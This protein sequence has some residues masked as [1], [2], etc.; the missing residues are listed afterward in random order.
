MRKW[1]RRIGAAVVVLTLLCGM[2]VSAEEKVYLV[3]V[4]RATNHVD[5]YAYDEQTGEYTIPIIEFTCSTGKDNGTP[6]AV[7][8]ISERDKFHPMNGGV[9]AQYAVR[10][11]RGCMFHAVPTTEQKKSTL[12]TSYYNKLGE[13]A[14]SGCVRL[15]AADSNWIYENC[16]DGTTVEVYEDENDLGPFGKPM[17]PKIPDGHPYADWDPTDPDPNNPWIEERPIV[18]LVANATDGVTLILPW[19]ASYEALY[20]SIGVFTPEGE[21]YA[22]DDYALDIYGVYNLNVARTYKLYIRGHDLATTLRGDLDI[23]LVVTE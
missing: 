11:N 22:A 7:T 15:T 6:I 3:R 19:G 14:S 18:K 21:A 16:A 23:T 2:T 10:F 1:W 13:Q 12:K 20:N 5:V 17:V 8:Q 9:F 4:N